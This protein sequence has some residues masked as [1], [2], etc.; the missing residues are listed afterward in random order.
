MNQQPGVAG[1]AAEAAQIS[2]LVLAGRRSEA[3]P[4]LTGPDAPPSK[5][6]LKVAGRPMLDRVLSALAH[7]GRFGEVAVSGLPAEA[8]PAGV[9]AAPA[10]G[11]PAAAILASADRPTP[12]FVT[13]CDHALL[14]PEIVRGF[15]D[16]A[17]REE[18]DICVGFATRRTIEASYPGMRRTY[19]EMGG[20]AYSSCNLFLIRTA[21]GFEAI[22][23][24]LSM[25][26]D[27]KRPFALARRIGPGLLLRFL[28]R[29]FTSLEGVFAYGS[30]R[31]GVRLKPVVLPFADAA[32]DVDKPSDLAV[33]EAILAARA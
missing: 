21:Q 31:I 7:T 15:L 9:A 11:S 14:T 24:W 4:L 17:G 3:D 28:F 26:R 22:R 1:R 8:L 33:V 2:A 5:A 12:L 27:R 18:A 10:G 25:E 16:R 19:L 20:E 13:T 32:I 23:F 6:F 30:R 29:R